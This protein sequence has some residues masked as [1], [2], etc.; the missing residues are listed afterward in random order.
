MLMGR[1]LPSCRVRFIWVTV[2]DDVESSEL[3]MTTSNT[4]ASVWPN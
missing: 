3:V 1:V 4:V 2:A